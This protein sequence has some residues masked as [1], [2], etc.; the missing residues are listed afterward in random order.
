MWSLGQAA[1]DPNLWT[2]LGIAGAI[3]ALS[4]WFIILQ[5]KRHA[6]ET[7]RL[8]RELDQAHQELKEERAQNRELSK[9]HM[10]LAERALPSLNETARVVA[11]ASDELRRSRRQ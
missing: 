8:E 11:E 10:A 4:V 2:Q 6:K 9:S 7:A 5:E 1:P 3:V